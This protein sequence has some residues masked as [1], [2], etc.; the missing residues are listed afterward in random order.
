M[1]LKKQYLIYINMSFDYFAI[2]VIN[3][4]IYIR[5]VNFNFIKLK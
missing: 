3:K 1:K 2:Q 4:S 5:N